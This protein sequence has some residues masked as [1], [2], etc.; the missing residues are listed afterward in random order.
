M[1]NEEVAALS[2]NPNPNPN[3]VAVD[4]SF[5]KKHQSM[6]DHLSNRHQTRLDNSLT[7]R[8]AK[9]DSSSSP[10][11]KSTSI[12]L[13]RFFNSNSFIESQ[14]AQYRLKSNPTTTK[15]LPPS[16]IS[17]STSLRTHTSYP[18]MKFGHRSRRRRICGKV[19]R[20]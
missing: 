4:P 9:S 14:L 1:E 8:F 5:Q 16:S 10:S 7:C 6:L 15:S 12:F 20:F 17:R 13:S 18:P 19:L 11:F 3:L 2:S